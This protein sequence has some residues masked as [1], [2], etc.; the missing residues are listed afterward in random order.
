MALYVPA[1]RRRRQAILFAAVA[2]VIGLVAGILIGRASAP[3][4]TGR[5]RAVQDDARRTAAELRVVSLH[6]EAGVSSTGSG[7]GGTG[8]VLQRTRA[9]LQREIDEAPWLGAA[10][11]TKLLD[12]L[13]ALEARTDRTSTAF[14]QAVDALASDIEATFGVNG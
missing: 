8:L 9:D 5:V 7:D 14:G 3:S 1:S 11:K 10:A 4:L 13:G 6:E 12:E 2:L